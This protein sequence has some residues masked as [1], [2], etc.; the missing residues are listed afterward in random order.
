MNHFEPRS[1]KEEKVAKVATNITQHKVLIK[2]K[3]KQEQK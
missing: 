3:L 2:W 1:P